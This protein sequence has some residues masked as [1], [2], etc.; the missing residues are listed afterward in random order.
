[1]T[2]EG[3]RTLEVVVPAHAGQCCDADGELTSLEMRD[4]DTIELRGRWMLS[5][6]EGEEGHAPPRDAVAPGPFWSRSIIALRAHRQRS[7]QHCRGLWLLLTLCKQVSS[8]HLLSIALHARAIVFSGVQTSSRVIWRALTHTHPQYSTRQQRRRL[9]SSD[10]LPLTHFLS[11]VRDAP[12]PS[13]H[14]CAGWFSLPLMESGE[15][16][17]DAPMLVCGSL[18]RLGVD[19]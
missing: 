3:I 18:I 15:H 13:S 19:G 16:L 1:M 11:R 14:K 17:A 2:R 4:V 6:A 10:P 8:S 9:T 5:G 12:A 7:R